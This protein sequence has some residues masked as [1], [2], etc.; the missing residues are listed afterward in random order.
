MRPAGILVLTA[1]IVLLATS[2]LNAETIDV[3][4]LTCEYQLHTPPGT[5]P[6]PVVFVLHGG[7]DRANRI[8][9]RMGWDDL[10]DQEGFAVVYPIGIN[11]GWND[12]RANTVRYDPGE[13]PDDV[14]FFDAL[15]DHLIAQGVA[16][17]EQVYVTGPSNG[18][19]MT[20]RLMC[21]RADRIAGAAPLIANMTEVLYPVCAPSRPVPV[22]IINGTEDALIPWDG[23]VIADNEDRGRVMS[24]VASVFFWSAANRCAGTFTE[25]QLPDLAPDDSSIVFRLD[26]QDCGA[27]VV[28]MRV[29]GGGHRVPGD[30]IRFGEKLVE[31]FL[32]AQNNEIRTAPYIWNF[33]Q[34][35]TPQT[36]E[37]A[38]GD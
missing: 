36:L 9:R 37:E 17:A 6:W 14:A 18:G 26:W 29:E 16:D 11:R 12:G 1:M 33:F 38:S 3:G 21:D 32:G 24:T 2:P 10:A 23:G 4:E 7:N 27:P 25:Q 28:L 8:R 35:L 30:T 20:Y 19:M 22:M 15:L 31:A 5:A 13:A 34:S